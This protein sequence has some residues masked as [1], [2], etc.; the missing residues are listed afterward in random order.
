MLDTVKDHAILPAENQI[1]VFS[2]QL[3]NQKLTAQVSHFI[4]MFNLKAE[5]P[6]QG[7]L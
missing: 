3:H 7:R 4:Q 6:F 1:T 2:H 5:N